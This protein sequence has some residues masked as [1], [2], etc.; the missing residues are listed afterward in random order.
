MTVYFVQ[1]DEGGP[2]KIGWA[3]NDVVTRIKTFQTGHFM[4]LRLIRIIDG[5]SRADE[6][7]LH[8]YFSANRIRGEWFHFTDAMLSVTLEDL[9]KPKVPKVPRKS[10]KLAPNKKEKDEIVTIFEK[11]FTLDGAPSKI[12]FAKQI[13]KSPGYITDLCKKRCMPSLKMAFKISEMTNG[14]VPITGW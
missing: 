10:P 9:I 3:G 14:E 7:N 6:A 12:D 1:A 8:R 5:A 2:V 11:W 13:G 4:E